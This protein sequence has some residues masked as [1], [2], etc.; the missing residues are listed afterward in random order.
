MLLTSER[1]RPCSARFRRWSSGRSTR[2]VP[3]SWRTVISPGSSRSRLPCGPFTATRRPSTLTSTPEGTAMGERPIRLIVA[4][5]HVAEDLAAHPAPPRLGVGHESLAG[6]EHGHAQTAEHPRELVGLCVDTKAGLRHPT[7]ARDR[8]CALGRVLHLDLQDAS[9]PARVVLHGEGG[10]V[11]LT[12]E[13][14]R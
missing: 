10:D 5:P 1:V 14:A 13:D 4:S 7:D 3:S 8:A 9:G 6:R 2:S 12:F 11:A